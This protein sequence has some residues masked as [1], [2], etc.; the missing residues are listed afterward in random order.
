L[1]ELQY[2]KAFAGHAGLTEFRNPWEYD[3][4]VIGG[5][6]L[7]D[8]GIHLVDHVQ[9]LL[10]EVEEVYGFA[11]SSVWNLDGSEDNGFALLRGANGKVASLHSSWTEWKGY[12]FCVQVYG[13][14]GMAEA[15]YGPMFA[16]SVLREQDGARRRRR[17]FYPWV[18]VREKLRGWQSTVRWTFEQE[19]RD[20]ANPE[21]GR[22]VPLASGADGLRAV[23]IAHAICV[24]SRLRA[25]VRMAGAT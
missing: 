2:I 17:R 11:S 22:T 5:G 21:P 6:T 3:R 24:S 4:D 25:P 14:R 19:L 18:A 12:H 1:G 23:E 13:D 10:G 8:N 20:F 15:S 7:M 9:Y 16:M